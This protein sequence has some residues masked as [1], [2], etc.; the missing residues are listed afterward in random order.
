MK[1]VFVNIILM[2]AVTHSSFSLETK[3][4]F[5]NQINLWANYNPKNELNFNSGLRWIPELNPGISFK[6]GTL[7]DFD[8]SINATAQLS[9]VPTDSVYAEGQIKF[10]RRWMRYSGDQFEIRA[11]LQKINFGSA[12][13]IRPLM[14]FD[15]IDPRDP[16]QLTDGVRGILGRYYF[17]NNAN[18]WLWVLY[19]NTE[20]R[21]FDI[22]K[23]T[24]N[25]PE[26]GGRLQ[27]PIPTGEAAITYHFRNAEYEKTQLEGIDTLKIPEHRLGFDFKVDIGIGLWVEASQIS[28]MQKIGMMTNQFMIN[29][30]M[31]YT[32]SIG[33]GLYVATEQLF[34]SYD[35]TAFQMKNTFGFTAISANYPIGIA[36]NINFISFIDWK[37]ENAYN[38]INWE[39]F[40]NPVKMYLIA[41]WNPEKYYLPQ[42]GES[43]AMFA[44]WGLQV[45]GVWNF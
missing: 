22:G 7:L 10:Y 35:S 19:G 13:I 36:D 14:W 21:P 32:F 23:S 45:L 5:E 44:G 41:Y 28:K 25:T 17:L 42:Q 9:T 15:Q 26:A 27:Y 29:L 24:K 39:H 2:L 33:N 3:L 43:G 18:I 8:V 6:N 16:L 20:Q 37:N 40:I 30:G 38:F 31:D 12:S 1:K 34:G 4:D 11:G